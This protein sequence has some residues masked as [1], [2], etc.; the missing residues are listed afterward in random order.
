MKNLIPTFAALLAVSA[1][2]DNKQTIE[3]TVENPTDFARTEIVAYNLPRGF[4][5]ARLLDSLGNELP[6]QLSADSS[7][8]FFELDI[9]PASTVRL[10]LVQGQP[11]QSADT[12]VYGRLYPE[13][14]DD[15]AWENDRAAY[16]AYG[17][18]LQ[19]TG[20]QAFGYDVWT[21]SVAGPVIEKR[22]RMQ[23]DTV[24]H[25]SYHIDHGEGM[26]AYAVGPT[27]GGGTAA[28]LDSDGNLL[29]PWAF[30]HSEILENG[31]LRL[32]FRLTYP[33]VVFGG[34]TITEIRTITLDKGSY[35]NHTDIEYRGLT[36]E[37]VVA[38]GIVVHAHNPK[39][40][41]L[42]PDDAFMTYID[43]TE[44]PDENNGQIFLAVISPQSEGFRY[45]AMD[46]PT[47][48]A[49]GHILAPATIRPGR[50][51]SY[52]WGSAWSKGGMSDSTAWQNEIYRASRAIARPLR[53]KNIER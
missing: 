52:Y 28:L 50:K 38:P 51:Y 46:E 2:G 1:C 12:A 42:C 40:Y 27:L 11:S 9:A 47:G 10:S 33:P 20:Q 6:G 29:Y 45:H 39:G 22:Y 4:A 30:E 49:V 44:R 5:P 7:R 16:R 53:I 18:A 41:T 36:H 17:P 23:L 8:I 32:S 13:R 3:F 26:D 24:N 25:Q 48:D 21:K 31:P 34:D 14:L 37:A 43:L 15:F 19:A 35:L